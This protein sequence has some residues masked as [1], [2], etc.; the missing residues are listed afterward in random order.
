[1]CFFFVMTSYVCKCISD[2][3]LFAFVC[4]FS[5][6][7]EAYRFYEEHRKRNV[8][9]GSLF[10]HS[11]ECER[12]VMN[13]ISTIQLNSICFNVNHCIQCAIE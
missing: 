7:T 5:V 6:P 9:I 12:I 4:F 2:L 10:M 3:I 1:M 11:L 13:E 8:S